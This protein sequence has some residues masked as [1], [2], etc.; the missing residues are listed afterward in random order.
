MSKNKLIDEYIDR[1]S[2]GDMNALDDLYRLIKSDVY[3]YALSKVLN[4]DDASDIMQ[5]TFMHI[6]KNAKLYKRQGKPMAWIITIESNLIKRYF[7]LKNREAIID[8]EVLSKQASNDNKLEKTFNNRLI[9]EMLNKLDSSEREIIVLHIV[10]NLKFREI[11]KMLDKPLS[12][13]LSKYNRAMKRLKKE[14]NYEQ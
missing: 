5:D 13:I 2:D 14:V 4:K 6:Y 12:T 1:L 3:A 11:A 7:N 10:S 8:D 9:D